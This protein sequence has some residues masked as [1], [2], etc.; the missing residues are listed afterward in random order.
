MDLGLLENSARA[1]VS[2]LIEASGLKEGQILVVGCSTSEITG[3]KIGTLSSM[4]AANAV[5]GIAPVLRE[6]DIP[7][8]A[9]LRTP[10]PGAGG[11]AGSG[12]KIRA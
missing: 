8:R 9:V 4:D 6:K 3:Y 11:R 7:C 12:R 2:E 1:A 5:C 10:E